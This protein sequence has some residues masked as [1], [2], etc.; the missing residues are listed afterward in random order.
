MTAFAIG[1]GWYLHCSPSGSR[2][3]SA[4]PLLGFVKM[5]SPTRNGRAFGLKE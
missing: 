3:L 5:K 2:W 4:L 1:A